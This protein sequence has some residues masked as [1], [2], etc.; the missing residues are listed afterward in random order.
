MDNFRV[1]AI[2]DLRLQIDNIGTMLT[3]E[4][5]AVD[6]LISQHTAALVQNGDPSGWGCGKIVDNFAGLS[7][8]FF[9]ILGGQTRTPGAY[10]DDAH[11]FIHPMVRYRRRRVS[12]WKPAA[13]TELTLNDG[14]KTAVSWSKAG[15]DNI[16][17]YPM[18]VGRE[19]NVAKR[20]EDGSWEHTTRPSLAKELC[21]RDVFRWLY[22]SSQQD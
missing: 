15:Q 5:E 11:E 2:T 19:F 3:F 13:V 9:R 12:S 1:R 4:V 17:E 22:P 7:G 6:L 10:S 18:L 16:P 20:N 21:P 14:N 8:T